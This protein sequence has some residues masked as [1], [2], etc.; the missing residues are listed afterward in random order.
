MPRK[1]KPILSVEDLNVLASNGS[2]ATDWVGGLNKRLKAWAKVELERR[3]SAGKG[4]QASKVVPGVK[5]S[6][7]AIETNGKHYVEDTDWGA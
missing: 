1:T 5:T 7:E 6:P 2:D 4:K 3:E